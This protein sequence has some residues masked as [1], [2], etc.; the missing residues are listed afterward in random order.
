[1]GDVV[2]SALA[3]DRFTLL[4]LSGF[5][6][7]ALLLAAVG[8]YG[9]VAEA[10]ASRTR[11]IGLRMAVGAA[12]TRIL[13]QVVLEGL[14]LATWGVALGCG[15]GA[16]LARL[17]GSLLYEVSP[18]DGWAYAAAAPLLVMLVLLASLIPAVRAA[19]L[20]PMGALRDG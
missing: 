6:A 8:V 15:G 14:V 12:R 7:A 4:L 18:A 17:L 13:R 10:V 2:A 16:L 19:R 11:E 1:M 3:P 20:D 5:A 9:V